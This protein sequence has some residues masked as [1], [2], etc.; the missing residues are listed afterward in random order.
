[1]MSRSDLLKEL[2]HVI[3]W[4]DMIEPIERS[5]YEYTEI[6]ERARDMIRKD[7]EYI[8]ELQHAPRYV[9]QAREESRDRSLVQKAKP[10]TAQDH[11]S[12]SGCW[13]YVCPACKT[14]IDYN[15]RY[16][17]HCGQPMD[18]GGIG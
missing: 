16:C 1:M 18:W 17:R 13:W 10:I 2:D 12:P 15:D 5:T 14:A 4:M 6:V 3:D 8:N 9:P 7:E 11:D